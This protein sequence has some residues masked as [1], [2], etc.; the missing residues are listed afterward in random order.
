MGLGGKTGPFLWGFC[1][2]G[3]GG[4]SHG[5]ESDRPVAC[6][7]GGAG[8]PGLVLARDGRG[9]RV[10]V[11]LKCNTVIKLSKAAC[12]QSAP[13]L[14]GKR[15]SFPVT[16]RGGSDGSGP[17]WKGSYRRL[18]SFIRHRQTQSNSI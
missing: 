17:I 8:L 13:T 7:V 11:L 9:G 15:I 2:W 14:N 10:F 3:L 4:V 1:V 16:Y 6:S 12:L 18:G 5:T